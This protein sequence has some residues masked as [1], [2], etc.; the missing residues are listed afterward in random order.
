MYIKDVNRSEEVIV[1]Q[2]YEVFNT[3][4]IKN[5]VIEKVKDNLKSHVNE[6]L[7]TLL[8]C[9]NIMHDNSFM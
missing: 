1:R 6:G 9:F 8:F 4:L 3:W 2:Q 7:V 5:K